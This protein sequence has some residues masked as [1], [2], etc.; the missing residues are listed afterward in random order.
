MIFENKSHPPPRG[1]SSGWWG[2]VGWDYFRRRQA[3]SQLG[4]W[5]VA[6][7]GSFS[8]AM[9]RKL[10]RR[11]VSASHRVK[12]SISGRIT[13]DTP[14]KLMLM[15]MRGMWGYQGGHRSVPK[16]GIGWCAIL[17]SSGW[18]LPRSSI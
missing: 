7:G 9:W 18:W 11:A 8:S 13:A 12:A 2:E 5:L 14:R 15:T 17:R 6:R 1:C 4:S 16:G 3:I 10:W